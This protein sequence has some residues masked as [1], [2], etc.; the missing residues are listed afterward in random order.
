[1]KAVFVVNPIAGGGGGLRAW[2]EWERE[3]SWRGLPADCRFTAGRGL[4]TALAAEAKNQGYDTVIG[5]GGCPATRGLI[6]AGTGNDFSKLLGYP[7][8]PPA[9]PS[10]SS[11]HRPGGRGPAGQG[12]PR[13][14]GQRAGPCR[15]PED[16]PGRLRTLWL[17]PKVFSGRHTLYPKVRLYRTTKVRIDSSE[18]LF[19]QADGEVFG[20]TNGEAGRE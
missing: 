13:I 19:V 15:R 9:L 11:D 12:P 16:V 6:P 3:L 5:V 2:R 14:R 4:A 1:M 7:R 18:P 20:R 10:D 8:D 17:L